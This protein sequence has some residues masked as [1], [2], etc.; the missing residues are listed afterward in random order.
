MV[1]KAKDIKGVVSRQRR[2]ATLAKKEGKYDIGQEKKEKAKGEPEMA[3]DSAR[4]A[5]VASAFAEARTRVA[6]EE[7]KKLK[8]K[9]GKK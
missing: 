5:R 1:A 3:K 8:S 6:N 2:Y 4:E 9:K 7:S